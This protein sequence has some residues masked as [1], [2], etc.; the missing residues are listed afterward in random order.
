[1][2]PMTSVVD[3]CS[4]PVYVELFRSA[5]AARERGLTV[6][7]SHR[8]TDLTCGADVLAVARIA[9]DDAALD[10][11][12]RPKGQIC[13]RARGGACPRDGHAARP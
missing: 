6:R 2:P 12:M 1:M 11:P 3:G 7:T 13:M 10:R 5:S 4:Y 8:V 9:I